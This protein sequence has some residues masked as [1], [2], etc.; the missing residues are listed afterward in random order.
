MRISEF[1]GVK[2]CPTCEGKRLRKEALAVLVEDANI[3][4]V[5][6]WPVNRTLEWV[7]TLSSGGDSPLNS[8]QKAIAERILREINA[9]GS[10]ARSRVARC[11]ASA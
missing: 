8:R 1:M 11:S 4:D 3:I 5:T 9:T 7:K 10:R 6:G 2:L